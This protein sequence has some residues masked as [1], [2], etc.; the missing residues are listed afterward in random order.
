MLLSCSLL[1]DALSLL[2]AVCTDDSAELARRA[3]ASRVHWVMEPRAARQ[4]TV[5]GLLAK[6]GLSG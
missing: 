4:S 6:F 2:L 5:G 1:L 3:N